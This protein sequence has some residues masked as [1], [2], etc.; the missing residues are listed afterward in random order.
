MPCVTDYFSVW[1]ASIREGG[2]VN[3]PWTLKSLSNV[4]R[5]RGSKNPNNMPTL[6]FRTSLTEVSTNKLSL[7][8]SHTIDPKGVTDRTGW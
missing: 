5:E 1:R 3:L 6:F 2:C 4:D 8:V 7:T